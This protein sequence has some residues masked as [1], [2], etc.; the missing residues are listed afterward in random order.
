MGGI[1]RYALCSAGLALALSAAG[2]SP[3]T[4]PPAVLPPVA[5]PS[6]L[7]PF[8][9]PLVADRIVVVKGERRLKLMRGDTVLREYKV[10]LGKNP[11]GHKQHEG[12]GR[13][14]EGVYHIDYRKPDSAFHLALRISYPNDQDRER[15]R[16]QGRPPGGAIMIHGLP[17]GKGGIGSG[18]RRSD[19]TE[20]CIAVTN[21]EIEEI[22]Q[23]VPLGTPIEIRS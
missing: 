13:T 10:A 23:A 2:C 19:W 9:E 3:P 5:L 4:Q 20:G 17:N 8:V 12:D 14:P 6:P 21:Q 7:L 11:D 1:G 16:A 22:W 18:H 15:A